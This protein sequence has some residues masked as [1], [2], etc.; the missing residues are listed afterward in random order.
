M[1][2]DEPSEATGPV[3]SVVVPVGR[4]DEELASQLRA[5]AA[6]DLHA[7]WELVLSLNTPDPQQ[8][9]E[10]DRLVADVVPV[11]TLVVDSSDR[12]DAAHARNV[13]A[14]AASAE[15][16]AFCDGDDEVDRAWLSALVAALG[17][18]DAVG[19]HLEETSLVSESQRHWR[20]PATPGALPTF[21]GAS[22]PV[23]ANMAVRRAL[24]DL[25]GGFREDLTRCEDIAFGWALIEHGHPAA[26]C[27]DAVVHYRHR[28]GYRALVRQ[29]VLYGR[30]M[31]EVIVRCGVPGG[32]RGRSALLTA[33][34]QQVAA[35]GAPYYVRR[36]S[37][38]IGR[39]I[40]IMSEWLRRRRDQSAPRRRW[41]NR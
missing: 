22:Y 3:V 31:S 16:L 7:P 41:R 40:G 1:N 12:R 35:R 11:P 8:R 20:P 2:A 6:Q 36:G 15:L 38:A 23:S 32:S 37:L 26:Y 18:S 17:R 5:L 39:G 33:N 30:G 21:L 34:N 10:L 13:G 19:G 14:A 28:S 4:V 24:F 25:V 27:P 29:H 9:R